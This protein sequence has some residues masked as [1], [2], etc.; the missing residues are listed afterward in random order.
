MSG[1]IIQPLATFASI[2]IYACS[3]ILISSIAPRKKEPDRLSLSLWVSDLCFRR[4]VGSRPHRNLVPGCILRPASADNYNTAFLSRDTDSLF[5]SINFKCITSSGSAEHC[6]DRGMGTTTMQVYRADNTPHDETFMSLLSSQRE[7][8]QQLTM[9]NSIR[10]SDLSATSSTT[11]LNNRKYE[12]HL[13]VNT[14]AQES[15]VTDRSLVDHPSTSDFVFSKRF[16]LGFGN[17]DN[18][19]L[20]SFNLDRDFDLMEDSC[21]PKAHKFGAGKRLSK[22]EDPDLE[23][24]PIRRKKRR[25]SSLGFLSSS[26]FEDHLKPGR[27]DSL[28]ML[29]DLKVDRKD[30]EEDDDEIIGDDDGTEIVIVDGDAE[31]CDE[32]EPEETPSNMVENYA[33]DPLLESK[34]ISSFE[35]ADEL[36]ASDHLVELDHPKASHKPMDTAKLKSFLES[37]NHAMERSQKSQQDIHDWDRKMG[38]KRSHSKTMRLS[39]R[40]RKKLRAFMKKEINSLGSKLL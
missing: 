39:S 10:R 4:V 23:E 25:L 29:C 38:L 28:Q 40:S 17:L 18:F 30:E 20:P 26:F 32:D 35:E 31:S 15:H 6:L 16:S 19:G 9:E 7:L 5:F 13:H 33:K 2:F 37:F 8:L 36:I 3:A 21:A 27:R 22:V 12:P 24:C 1:L 34:D 14:S 11:R